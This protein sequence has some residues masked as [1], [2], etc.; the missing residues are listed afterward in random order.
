MRLSVLLIALTLCVTGPSMLFA[1]GTA[2]PTTAKKGEPKTLITKDGWNIATNYF[3][4]SR[5][6]DAA[7]VVIVPG[8]NDNQAMWQ[9]FAAELNSVHDL[10]VITVDLRKQPKGKTTPP[11]KAV[12][13]AKNPMVS[14]Q[15]VEAMLALDLEAVKKFIY[16]EHQEKRLN[17]RRLGLVAGDVGTAVAVQYAVLDWLKTPHDDGPTLLT[18][19]PRGQD[20]QALVLLSPTDTH[21]GTNILKGLPVLREAGVA[22]MQVYS[23]KAKKDVEAADKIHQALG[24]NKTDKPEKPKEGETAKPSKL[25]LVPLDLTA[26]KG[27]DLLG[28]PVVIGNQSVPVNAIIGGFLAKHLKEPDIE[29]RDRKSKL[30]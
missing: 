8:K 4:S 15:D 28:K 27:V 1:Q 22:C 30:E 21:P 13:A 3:T 10:A 14:K 25:A 11:E 19:T 17:M 9:A 20:V 6:K 7:V 24:G 18:R 2:K 5:E 16:E 12:G 26:A 29:W 23:T